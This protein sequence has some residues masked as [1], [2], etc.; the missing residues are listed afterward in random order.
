MPISG[1][2]D[3][4]ITIFL[5]Y[6]RLTVAT[7]SLSHVEQSHSCPKGMAYTVQRQAF[8]RVT[9]NTSLPRHTASAQFPNT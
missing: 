7:W 5:W 8:S 6:S 2:T 9:R 3:T 4:P 1:A